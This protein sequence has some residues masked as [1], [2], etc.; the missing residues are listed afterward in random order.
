MLSRSIARGASRRLAKG[1]PLPACKATPTPMYTRSPSL[2][3]RRHESNTPSYTPGPAQ[4]VNAD[5]VNFPGAVNSK[6]TTAM[7]FQN[8]AQEL[9][10]PTYRYMD[11]DGNVVD[12]SRE[13]TPVSDEEVTTWYRNMLTVSIMDL[14]M[15]DAQR[16]GR[17]SFYM[18]SAGEE[19]IAV[20][21][22][23]ALDSED[24]CFLQYREQGVLVQRGF[25]LTEMMNQLFANKDDHGKGRNMPVHYGSG[26]LNVHTVS[27]PLA[28][29]IPQASGAAYALKMQSL[30]N[31]N[32]KKRI[33]ACYFGE[34]AASE[35][36]FHAALNIAA[37]KSCPVVF[38][39]RNNGFAISTASIEQYKGDGIASRGLGYGID[40]IR[41][42]GNDIFAVREVMIEAR[43][44][45]LEG[46][47]KPILIEAMS[48]RVSHHST[49]DDSFAYRAKREVEEWKRRDN[50][51]TRL[52]KWMENKG[53]WN[54]DMEKEARAS[55]RKEVLREFAAAEKLKKPPIR[56][57]FEDVYEEITPEAK[58][59]MRELKRVVEKY[60]G[61]YDV[62][63]F[64]G[65]L[66][67]LNIE[68][69]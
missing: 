8:P 66:E 49:S 57:M 38:V 47:C 33:V 15:F 10:M 2:D 56:A 52:R 14:I 65:G 69:K 30:I 29:Q 59:Q 41:V 63:S 51:I 3:Q 55:I 68:A 45:A 22:A 64:E 44:K 17:T 7:A 62:K 39:C 48:Y 50:P 13:L 20:G 40:T 1:T 26:K 58:A 4:K 31:P 46:D 16:Q 36:D 53:I 23:S 18:V 5:S 27:S 11:A 24:V 12:T 19:G 43:K 25:T 54:E 42:D 32:V 67:T 28:T 35:G 61:E 9:A 34:G 6:F 60:P 37:T 21:T